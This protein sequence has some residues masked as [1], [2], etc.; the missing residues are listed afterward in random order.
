MDGPGV[1]GLGS[2]PVQEVG[3][4]GECII[5]TVSKGNAIK[6]DHFY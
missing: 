3:I 6:S 4:D 5:W 1:C 2:S